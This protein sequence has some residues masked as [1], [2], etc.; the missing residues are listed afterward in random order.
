MRIKL[1]KGKQNELINFFKQIN[2]Y[3]W[4]QFADVLN[5]SRTTLKSWHSEKILLPLKVFN[6]LDVKQHYQNYIVEIRFWNW[7]QVKGGLN[8]SGNVKEI[9]IPKESTM[10]AEFIGIILGDGNIF[11]FCKGKKIRVY[12]LRIAGHACD[13]KDYLT[14]HVSNLVTQLF[15]LK[16]KFYFKKNSNC[17]YLI[18]HSFKVIEFFSKMGIL[19]GNK[20]SNQSTFPLWIWKHNSYLKACVR[21]LIDTDGSVYELLPHWPGL[22]QI[23]FSNRNLKLL[24]DTRNALIQLEY[25]VSRISGLNSKKTPQF[26]ITKKSD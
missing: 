20:I 3:N 1:K 10:L 15:G 8:S 24:Y 19:P 16:P 17:L 12:M 25:S 18:L 4:T 22:F 11:S 6:I 2:D 9:K 26:Y 7:S 5:V 23:C 21:G 13:D 14:N